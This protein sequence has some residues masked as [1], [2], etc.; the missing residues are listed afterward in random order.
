M[1]CNAHVC[2]YKLY[3]GVA[4]FT[5]NSLNLFTSLCGFTLEM[6]VHDPCDQVLEQT[7]LDMEVKG[8][9]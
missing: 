1:K 2:I 3:L 5:I 8:I 7:H 9:N 6:S 4:L